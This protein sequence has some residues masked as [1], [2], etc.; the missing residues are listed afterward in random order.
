MAKSDTIQEKK[1]CLEPSLNPDLNWVDRCLNEIK[2]AFFWKKPAIIGIHRVNF[3]GF[4]NQ[5]NRD[6][7]LKS[8]E[9]LLKEILKR[10]PEVEFMSSDKLGKLLS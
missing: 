4:I 5:K 7:N 3:I 6:R 1:M 10:W 8:F 9:H 2:T